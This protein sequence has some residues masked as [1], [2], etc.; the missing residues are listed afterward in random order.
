MSEQWEVQLVFTDDR[1][2]KFWRAR[3]KGTTLYINY[4]RAGT[5]G[6]TS[7]KKLGSA[8]DAA[9]ALVKQAD[10]KRR[11]GYVDQEGGA[12]A[13]QGAGDAGAAAEKEAGPRTAVLVLDGPR[14][15]EVRLTCDGATV[16][17]EVAEIYDSEE[18]A[19]TAF[20]RIREAMVSEGYR[21][22]D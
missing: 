22:S 12:A 17:T 14:R 20:T 9:A 5:S 6:Q 18:A 2:N 15:V 10:G 13:G 1:S 7:V 3:T 11:K 16:R 4:G 8:E 21:S 19:A